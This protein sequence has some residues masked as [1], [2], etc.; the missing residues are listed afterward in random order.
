MVKLRTLVKQVPPATFIGESPITIEVLGT[1]GWRV[2]EHSGPPGNTVGVFEGYIDLSGY[3]R[4]DQTWFTRNIMIQ[5]MAQ[6]AMSSTIASRMMVHEIV[7]EVKL[8]DD[9]LSV[10]GENNDFPGDLGHG[11][12][13]TGHDVNLQSILFGR[14]REFAPLTTLPATSG[15]CQLLSQNYYGTNSGTAASKLWCYVV[16]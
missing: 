10:L 7:S 4:E 11:H 1:S 3:V 16:I 2:V 6:P 5:G 13:L 9:Q 15:A 8:S 12:E 14:V